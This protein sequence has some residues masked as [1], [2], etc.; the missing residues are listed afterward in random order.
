[1]ST[2]DMTISELSYETKVCVCVCRGGGGLQVGVT[3]LDVPP[4]RL[5][6]YDS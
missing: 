6:R 4:G 2:P 1:M 3:H 5:S